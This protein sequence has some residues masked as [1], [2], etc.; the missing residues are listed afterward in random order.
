MSGKHLIR[1]NDRNIMFCFSFSN[2]VK[3]VWRGGQ[4]KNPL[5]ELSWILYLEN[6][7]RVGTQKMF[8]TMYYPYKIFWILLFRWFTRDN[9][10]HSLWVP[11]PRPEASTTATQ[12]PSIYENIWGSQTGIYQT[13]KCCYVTAICEVATFFM[14]GIYANIGQIKK[15]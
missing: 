13:I 9:A 4:K 5:W 11:L 14:S 2:C 3:F 1:G 7:L 6:K 15:T 8:V 10:G 12:L